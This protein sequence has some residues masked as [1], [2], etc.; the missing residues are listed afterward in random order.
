MKKTHRILVADDDEHVRGLL[1]IML[2][3]LGHEVETASDGF[4][5]LTALA[6][7]IDLILL[8][9]MMPGMDGFDVAKKV[10]ESETYK[11]IPI[12]MVTGFSS[13]E[14]RVNAVKAGANDFICKPVE[15]T[16]L[17]VRVSSLLRMKD[18][19]DTVKRQQEEL[20]RMVDRRTQSLRQ[21]MQDLTRAQRELANAHM[22]TIHRLVVAAEFKDS[23]TAGHIQ[24]MS[25]FSAMLARLMKFPPG[26][27]ELILHASPMHDIGKIGTPEEILLKPGKL[28]PPQWALMQ[29]H[30]LMGRQILMDSSSKLLQNGEIIAVSHHEKWDGTG[31]PYGLRQDEIPLVGRICSVA[32]VFDALTSVRPYKGAIPNHKALKIMQK[33]SGIHFDPEIFDLFSQNMRE[34]EEIQQEFAMVA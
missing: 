21:A 17:K 2:N 26:A 12:I 4:E 16:E 10:R 25:H 3:R 32:D 27:V 11:D 18:A 23:G 22:E 9:V 29:Q 5:A 19:Q 15:T 6:F 20:E 30:P 24:R 1:K 8:D 7:D 34:V 33:G 28:N 14:D 31:Y 13:R